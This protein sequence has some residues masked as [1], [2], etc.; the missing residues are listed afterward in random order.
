MK[1]MKV[2]WFSRHLMTEDQAEKL[3]SKL[4][5]IE[6]THV[7]GTAPN[8]HVP[9]LGEIDGVVQE[10]APLK[11]LI[12]DFNVIAVVMPI[13]LLQQI[14][15][16]AGERPVIQALNKRLFNGGEKV[17]FAFEKWQRVKKIE[18]E[19]EDF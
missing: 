12:K 1:K 5:E 19:L 11:E 3:I 8:V 15:P 7:N 2:M 16:F 18:I 9:F 13:G 10:I 14:L 17:T 6:V 4:G